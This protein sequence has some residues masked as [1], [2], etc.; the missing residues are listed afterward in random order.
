MKV[1][2]CYIYP[3]VKPQL[4]FQLANRFAESYRAFP[5]GEDHA[6]YVVCN[7]RSGT[8]NELRMFNG[9]PVSFITHDNM[10]WDI[11]AFQKFGDQVA[12]DLM[13]CFGS[14]VHFHRSGWLAKMADVFI[15]Q[16]PGLYG[17]TAYLTPQLHVRTTAFWCPPELLQS[18]PMYIGSSK[19]SRYEFEHGRNSF[20]KHVMTLGFPVVMVT[21]KGCFPFPQWTQSP[22]N[23]IINGAPGPTDILVRDQ[24]IHG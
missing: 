3:M 20:T 2:I 21:W 19:Q 7:G 18:Y 17:A 22:Y 9:L 13:V 10:G 15:Q 6:L 11:G 8:A 1:A 14:H 12:C 5:A 24:F 23:P 16:G 4:Y